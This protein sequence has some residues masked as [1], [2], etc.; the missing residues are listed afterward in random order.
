MLHFTFYF[1]TL[2]IILNSIIK[3]VIAD[4]GNCI[5]TF[6]NLII[7]ASEELVLYCLEGGKNKEIYE[8]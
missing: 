8:K 6:L 2:K 3:R 4:L 1:K 5:S 7:S